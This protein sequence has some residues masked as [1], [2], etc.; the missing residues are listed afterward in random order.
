MRKNKLLKISIITLVSA[1]A[2]VACDNDVIAKPTGYDD[3]SPVVKVEDGATDIYNNS[4][5]DI[6][7]LIRDGTLASDVLD[8]LLYQYSV[9]VFGNYNA[10]TAHKISDNP[11]SE[12]TLKEAVKGLNSPDNPTD[13]S[14]ATKQFIKSHSAY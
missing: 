11:F 12:A 4:F 5:K 10:V 3:N 6:Y 2:L 1:F 9:S 7:D 14:A 8:E 13:G